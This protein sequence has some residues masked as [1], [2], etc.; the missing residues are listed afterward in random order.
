MDIERALPLRFVEAEAFVECEFAMWQYLCTT[1]ALRL[2]ETGWI[3]S[4]EVGGCP[5]IAC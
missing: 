3:T 2:N 1:P 5:W 4:L